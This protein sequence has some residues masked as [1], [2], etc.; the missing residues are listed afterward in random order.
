MSD[1]GI[2][3]VKP[4]KDQV[5]EYLRL[6][7]RTG[8]LLPGSTVNLDATSKKL[9]ISKTPLRDALI[10][11]EVEGFVEIYP[12]RGVVVS[13]LTL[14]TIREA[15]RVIGA[16][17]SSSILLAAP[18]QTP[19]TLHRMGA[20]Q[21]E[22]ES[23]FQKRDFDAYH[24]LNNEI[25]QIMTRVDENRTMKRIAETIKKRL[26]DFPWRQDLVIGWE[27]SLILEHRKML[28]F[29]MEGKFREASDFMRD[30]HWCYEVQEPF[31]RQHYNL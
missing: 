31:I 12:R 9:G 2:L 7:M 21:I 4:L 14:E 8:E 1:S 13:Q 30:V 11:L 26:H 5:Y 28:D 29:M 17:E 25:H 15:Y 20:L 10:M 19:D 6:Q 16:L 18:L 3:N 23:A 27:E 24:V 22:M